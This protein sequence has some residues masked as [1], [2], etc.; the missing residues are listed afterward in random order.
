MSALRRIVPALA[1]AFALLPASGAGAKG[2][3]ADGL[4]LRACSGPVAQQLVLLT[5]R[6]SCAKAQRLMSTSVNADRHCPRGWRAFTGV[7]V[8]GLQPA[9]S[10]R[11]ALT[12]C[13]RATRSGVQ[14]FTYAMPQG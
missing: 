4:H 14:A 1:L 3:P 5:H 8:R 13:K 9:S 11:H 10:R 6:V 7:H 12:L 2:N